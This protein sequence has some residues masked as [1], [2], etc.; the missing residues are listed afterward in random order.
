M[1]NE[2]IVPNCP[3]LNQIENFEQS[4]LVCTDC[5]LEV[6]QIFCYEP[7]ISNDSEILAAVSY[8]NDEHF[9]FIDN[10]IRRSDLPDEFS[11]EIYKYF[12]KKKRLNK[13]SKDLNTL[14]AFCIYDWSRKHKTTKSTIEDIACITKIDKKKIFKCE[15]KNKGPIRF[16]DV[17]SILNNI[18][19]RPFKLKESDRTKLISICNKFTHNDSQPKSIAAVL[20]QLY[21]SLSQ[22]KTTNDKIKKTFNVSPM[23]LY[24][25]K[26]KIQNK[27]IPIL[28]KIL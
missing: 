27:A 20:T 26:K 22:R 16:N 5:G 19:L 2:I 11:L 25:T 3:H 24:R 1:A 28:K 13:Q 12:R 8:Y 7:K 4:H 14:A 15:I 9:E 18:D 23:T 10:T 21:C 17:K 6:E